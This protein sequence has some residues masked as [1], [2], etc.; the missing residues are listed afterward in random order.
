MSV[1]VHVQGSF[2]LLPSPDIWQDYDCP[3]CPIDIDL[4]DV[5]ILAAGEQCYCSGCGHM[6]AAEDLN[7][8]TYIRLSLDSEEI[9]F[10]GVPK[11]ARRLRN[12]SQY[13]QKN[14]RAL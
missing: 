8:Q 14:W 2:S 7:L 3:N 1:A 6:H 4:H 10:R 9:D 5:D 12:E 13:Y 11:D